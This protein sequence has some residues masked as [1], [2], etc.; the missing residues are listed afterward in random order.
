MLDA[1]LTQLKAGTSNQLAAFF[2]DQGQFIDS[3]GKRWR[4]RAEIE[5]AA[6][7]LLA[8][9]AKRNASFRVE[10]T[11]LGPSRTLIASILWEFA[12][13]SADRSKS[14]LRMSIVLAWSEQEWTILLVQ[15]TSL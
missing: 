4:S 10:D 13:A 8:P 2:D 1:F 7:T 6:E 12:A 14:I 15:V 9:F 11:R 5:N 3:C